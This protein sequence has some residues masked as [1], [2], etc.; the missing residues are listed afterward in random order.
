MGPRE[1]VGT[2]TFGAKE[3]VRPQGPMGIQA[4]GDRGRTK[5]WRRR[6]GSNIRV[7]RGGEAFGAERIQTFGAALVRHWRPSGGWS[8]IW[9]PGRVLHVDLGGKTFGPRE[10]G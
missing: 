10:G 6:G 3:A 5:I 7:Q 9:A 4:F 8:D 1:V 2:R